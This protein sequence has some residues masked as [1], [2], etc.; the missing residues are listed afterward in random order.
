MNR[1]FSLGVC[2]LLILICLVASGCGN[3][4]LSSQ[5]TTV[6]TEIATVPPTEAPTEA[7]TEPP[8][9]PPTEPPTEAPT[10]PELK[11]ELNCEEYTFVRKGEVAE[12]YCGEVEAELVSWVSEDPGVAIV[13]YGTV[14]SMGPGET[15]IYGRY[16]GQEVSCKVTCT[17]NADDPMPYVNSDLLHAPVLALPEVS[18]ESCHYY[19]DAAFIGDSVSY[20]LYQWESMYDQLGEAT[21]LVRGA[22]GLENSLDGRLKIFHQGV[23]KRAEDAVKDSG[24]KKIF[25][26]M[27]TNDLGRFGIE[28]TLEL[29]DEFLGRILDKS[30]DVEVHIQSCTPIWTDAQVK[31]FTNELFDEYNVALKAYADEHGYGFVD[32]A[33]YFKDHTNGMAKKYCG[34][35]YVHMSYEGTAAWAKVLKAYAEEQMQGET[36]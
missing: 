29:W 7:P 9:A 30:P 4:D 15:T 6:P 32:V 1:R 33:P 2:T 5:A 22:F 12:L 28:G 18:E 8:T 3:T 10:E 20:T 14:V 23:Q 35:F 24:V 31:N 26:M 25:V 21:F 16:H 19:D 17:A 27:G 36:Q 13:S 34:D 11:I